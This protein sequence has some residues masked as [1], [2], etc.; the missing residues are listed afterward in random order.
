VLSGGKATAVK[1][2]IKSIG[3]PR[4]NTAVSF[5][6]PDLEIV[7]NSCGFVDRIAQGQVKVGGFKELMGKRWR[8]REGTQREVTHA[9]TLD[10]DGDVFKFLY[11]N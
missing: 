2:R 6:A 8:W 5:I 3:G 9:S 7:G 1:H 11:H 4:R 10:Q